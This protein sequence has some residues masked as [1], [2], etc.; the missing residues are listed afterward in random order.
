MAVHNKRVLL[1]AYNPVMMRVSSPIFMH[2]KAS[3][4]VPLV[5]INVT[6]DFGQLDL[7]QK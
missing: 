2:R 5:R 1:L 3:T 7:L 4:F 6:S